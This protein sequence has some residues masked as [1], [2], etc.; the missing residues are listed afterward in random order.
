MNIG[1]DAKK[2]QSVHEKHESHEKIQTCIES[3]L[4]H[5]R[6]LSI[7]FFVAFVLFVNQSPFGL[8]ATWYAWDA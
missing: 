6:F 3:Y 8:E 5:R 7:E 2:K 4:N 1:N